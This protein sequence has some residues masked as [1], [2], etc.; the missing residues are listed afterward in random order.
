MV[1]APTPP[2][3][4]SRLPI[5]TQS[6]PCPLYNTRWIHK[7]RGRGGMGGDGGGG[8]LVLGLGEVECDIYPRE[9]MTRAQI[10]PPMRSPLPTT[11]PQS[12]LS[13]NNY[14]Q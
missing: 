5:T 2:P 10:N 14:L 1:R 11:G 9:A 8:F 12:T 4:R 6:L 13:P 7:V 3:L